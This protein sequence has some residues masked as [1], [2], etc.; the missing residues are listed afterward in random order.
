M[1]AIV[2][3][4]SNRAHYYEELLSVYRSSIIQQKLYVSRCITK[5]TNNLRRVLAWKCPKYSDYYRTTE[6]HE[7]RIEPS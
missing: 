6:F 7:M 3:S 4:F 5:L 2:P 1:M